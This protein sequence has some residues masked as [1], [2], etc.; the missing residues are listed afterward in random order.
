MWEPRR[1]SNLRAI[2]A[3]CRDSFIF[4]GQI[5]Y[6]IGSMWGNPRAVMEDLV[7]LAI[8]LVGR[9]S[10]GIRRRKNGTGTLGQFRKDTPVRIR[11]RK[12]RLK[13]AGTRCADHATSLYL[14]K[15]A[16]TSPRSGGRSTGIVRLRTESNCISYSC[17][18]VWS[19]PETAEHQR[20]CIR[21]AH[22]LLHAWYKG[23]GS[24]AP[25]LATFTCII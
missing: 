12:P 2:T 13:T 25:G 10:T 4:N 21:N 17:Q 9:K 18:K 5:R 16:A 22:G 1:L 11:F 8:R 23:N 15:F 7:P 24:S 6:I 14:R 19:L 20:R 3:C